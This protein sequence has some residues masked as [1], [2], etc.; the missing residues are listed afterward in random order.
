MR[1]GTTMRFHKIAQYLGVLSKAVVLLVFLLFTSTAQAE[2]LKTCFEPQDDCPVFIVE[3]LDD[4][5]IVLVQA[6]GFTHP[7]ILDALSRVKKRGGTVRVILDASNEQARYTGAT[8]MQNH[9]IPVLIDYAPRIAHS[10]V[11][12]LD[13]KTV[14]TGSF[15]FTKSAEKNA[16]NLIAIIDNPPIAL[17]Y[18]KN[19][20]MREKVSRPYALRK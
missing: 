20:H 6:Y 1:D 16:E 17:L 12:I 19:W 15:N 10:K 7:K 8:F 13:E 18:T 4:A 14:I 9:G 3:L 5:D 11:L 2:S